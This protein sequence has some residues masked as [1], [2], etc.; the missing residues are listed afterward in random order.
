MHG[1]LGLGD[2]GGFR[3]CLDPCR[4]SNDGEGVGGAGG[5]GAVDDCDEGADAAD[6]DDDDDDVDDGDG[7]D[8]VNDRGHMEL[9]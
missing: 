1:V 5:G 4:T 2:W 3:S 9:N 8:A 6:D 7:A